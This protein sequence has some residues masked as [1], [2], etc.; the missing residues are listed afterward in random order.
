MKVRVENTDLIASI[1]SKCV[2][3]IWAHMGWNGMCSFSFIQ[4]TQES[5]LLAPAPIQSNTLHSYLRECKRGHFSSSSFFKLV[6]R[7]ETAKHIP[8]YR[9]SCKHFIQR[10]KS[11]SEKM[12]SES[13]SLTFCEFRRAE[14]TLRLWKYRKIN[15]KVALEISACSLSVK[16]KKC[17]SRHKN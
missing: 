5:T 17:N 10:S 6:F 9:R 1:V 15:L 16:L 11:S 14:V 8:E 12:R 4:I 13:A 3:C 7:M 2:T